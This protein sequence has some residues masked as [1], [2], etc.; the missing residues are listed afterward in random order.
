MYI[1]NMPREEVGDF[2]KTFYELELAKICKITTEQQ[3]DGTVEVELIPKEG[4]FGTMRDLL[5]GCHLLTP[6]VRYFHIK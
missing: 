1:G 4:L 6:W 3:H 2:V 5:H